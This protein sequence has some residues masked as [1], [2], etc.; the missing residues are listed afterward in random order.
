VD[1]TL[2]AA[3]EW[4]GI[5]AAF[6]VNGGLMMHMWYNGRAGVRLHHRRPGAA[7]ANFRFYI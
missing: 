2:N 6:K 4:C 5:A 3:V 7:E 1:T